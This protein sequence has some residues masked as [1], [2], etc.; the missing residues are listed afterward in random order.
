MHRCGE[1]FQ[2]EAHRAFDKFECCVCSGQ[3]KCK[4]LTGRSLMAIHDASPTVPSNQEAPLARD[5]SRAPSNDG[6]PCKTENKVR[7]KRVLDELTELD[8]ELGLR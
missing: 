7:R 1:V 8:E 3:A 6:I 4:S 2:R 5:V